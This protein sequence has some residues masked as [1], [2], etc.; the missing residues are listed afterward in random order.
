[1]NNSETK[2]PYCNFI[3]PPDLAPDGMLSVLLV[4]ATWEEIEDVAMWFKNGNSDIGFNVYLYQD[5]MWEPDWLDQVKESVS[6]VIVNTEQSAIYDKKMRW[7]KEDKTWYYG[8]VQ[9]KGSERQLERPLDW[10]VNHAR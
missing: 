9:F 10:F 8:P 3:T 1:M 5:S 4:D 2:A 7:V 6:V